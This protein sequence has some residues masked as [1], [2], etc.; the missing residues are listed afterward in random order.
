MDDETVLQLARDVSDRLWKVASGRSNDVHLILPLSSRDT[1][2][3]SEQESKIVFSQ[4]LEER[5]LYYSIETPTRLQYRQSGTRPVGARLDLTVYSDPAT[6]SRGLNVELKA[7][8]PGV[9]SF[10]KDFEKLAREGTPGLWFHTLERA[11]ERTVASVCAKMLRA[12]SDVDMHTL[13][14]SHGI[15]FAFCILDRRILLTGHLPLGE[16]VMSSS[17]SLLGP[18]GVGWTVEGAS[19]EL[20]VFPPE[21]RHGIASARPGVRERRAATTGRQSLLLHLPEIADDTLLHFS[22]RGDS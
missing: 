7:G 15:T 5:R 13:T 2:R 6:R 16:D 17:Q 21:S 11:T 8:T 18:D 22:S 14:A 4:V 3:V 10:R 1:D 19:A 9:E 12:L 20:F